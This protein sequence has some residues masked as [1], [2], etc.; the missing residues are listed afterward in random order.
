MSTD[1]QGSHGCVEQAIAASRQGV[2]FQFG[3]L[4]ASSVCHKHDNYFGHYSSA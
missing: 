4:S 2:F 1:M 3:N